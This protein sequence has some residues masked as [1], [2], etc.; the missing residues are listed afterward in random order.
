MVGDGTELP[1][2]HIGKIDLADFGTS[3][4]PLALRNILLVPSITNNLISISKFTLD[5]NVIVEFNSAS[6]YVK[7]KRTRDVLLKGT[8]SSGLYQLQLPCSSQ[9]PASSQLS[10]NLA[11]TDYCST[12]QSTHCCSNLSATLFSGHNTIPTSGCSCSQKSLVHLWHIRLG[13]PNNVVLTKVLSHLQIASSSKSFVQ[14]CDA[15][16]YGVWESV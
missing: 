7:D 16:Q 12:S 1:I 14:F 10:S 15:C 8:L 2:S 11:S 5:N 9:S 4:K 13:H 6:C 3:S